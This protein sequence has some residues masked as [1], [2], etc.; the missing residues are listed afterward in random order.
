MHKIFDRSRSV[1]CEYIKLEFYTTSFNSLI[2][3]MYI[4]KYIYAIYN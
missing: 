3:G 4:E 1:I 2:I